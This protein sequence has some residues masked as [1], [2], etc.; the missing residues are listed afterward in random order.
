MRKISFWSH[1]DAV[2]FALL[3]IVL[4]NWCDMKPIGLKGLLFAFLLVVIDLLIKQ[5]MGVYGCIV[6]ANA[7]IKQWRKVLLC[8][9]YYVALEG[10]MYL[11]KVVF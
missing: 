10:L 5:G 7:S 2:T 6:E 9:G 1:Y 11:L 3:Y 4:W 8:L